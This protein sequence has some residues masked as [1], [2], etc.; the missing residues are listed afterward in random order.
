MS[1]PAISPSLAFDYIPST[2]AGCA[3]VIA[4]VC[5]AAALLLGQT[6]IAIGCVLLGLAVV[7]LRA[8]YWVNP[9][10]QKIAESLDNVAKKVTD[11][12]K[13]DDDL[14]EENTTE[15]KLTNK[16]Q[17]DKVD[18]EQTHQSIKQ[19]LG[20]PQLKIT[21][22]A[23]EKTV[24]ELQLQITALSEEKQGI[25][26]EKEALSTQLAAK[27]KQ[28]SEFE[29]VE[30][31]KTDELTKVQETLAA[32]K[33]E[34][35]EMKVQHGQ[36]IAVLTEELATERNIVIQQRARIEALEKEIDEMLDEA[37]IPP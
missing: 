35:G 16:I 31:Q 5:I 22:D 11:A 7:S 25:H 6:F 33:G 19:L 28:I 26:E 24:A 14:K 36:T 32:L 8:W 4:I 29:I 37:E 27:E 2:I 15:E 23:L 10:E 34:V 3:A 18:L 12:T 9:L 21:N 17:Q 1:I 13:V 20:D 30:K